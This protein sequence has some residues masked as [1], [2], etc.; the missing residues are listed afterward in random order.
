MNEVKF[1]VE[2]LNRTEYKAV[3]DFLEEFRREQEEKKVRE[4]IVREFVKAFQDFRDAGG[5]I[6]LPG[7]D[8]YCVFLQ[9]MEFQ[10]DD[11]S[12]EYVERE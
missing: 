10:V 6:S 7:Y 1:K 12:T 9:D 8:A 4:A 11:I 3:K 5:S 2:G